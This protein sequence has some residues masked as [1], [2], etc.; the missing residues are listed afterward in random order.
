[1]NIKIFVLFICVFTSSLLFAQE[2]NQS[3]VLKENDVVAIC[4]DSITSNG[5]YPLFMEAYHFMCGPKTKVKF[6]NFGRWG[7]RAVKFLPTIDE[8]VLPSKPT[9]VTFCYGMNSARGTKPMSESSQISWGKTVK[10]TIQKFKKSGVRKFILASPGVIDSYYF[11]RSSE[12][13]APTPEQVAT[14]Q[15]NLKGLRDQAEKVSKDIKVIFADLHSPMIEVMV[16]AKAKYGKTFAFAGGMRDGIHPGEA[17]H[18]VMLFGILKGLG[19]SGNIGSV[20]VDLSTGKHSSSTGH[21]VLGVKGNIIEVESVRYPFCFF[22]SSKGKLD[23]HSTRSVSDLFSFNKDLNRLTLIVKGIKTRTA[24]LTWGNAS[25]TF[26][27]EELEKGIN[28]AD[29]FM[30]DN[31]FKNTFKKIFNAMHERDRVLGFLKKKRFQNEGMRKRLAREL[32][33]IKIVPVKHQLLIEEI[34]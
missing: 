7:W 18:L 19:Y 3:S 14:T 29:A 32:V 20:N 8:A 25:K 17:G 15:S 5:R 30:D 12:I 4:G 33:K 10:E 13:K 34:K 21:V 24:K 31:P 6:I 11:K 9:V 26:K 22:K 27:R 16:K 28:L 23:S 1:M 2:S